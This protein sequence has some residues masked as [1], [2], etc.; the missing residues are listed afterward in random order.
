MDHWNLKTAAPA[1]K[2]APVLGAIQPLPEPSSF[3]HQALVKRVEELEATLQEV[4]VKRKKA[5]RT[6]R[7]K[8]QLFPRWIKSIV[9]AE[10]IPDEVK[11]NPEAYR[12]IEEREHRELET[13]RG[14]VYWRVTRIPKFVLKADKQ[15]K[16]LAS[17]APVSSV[18]G[19]LCGPQLISQIV[20]DKLMALQPKIQLGSDAQF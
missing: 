9:V 19:T 17:P 4:T 16:P 15:E 5:K 6:L 18:P 7:T 20:C 8:D 2:K 1:V 11:A 10:L 12:I 13:T 14:E 3:D